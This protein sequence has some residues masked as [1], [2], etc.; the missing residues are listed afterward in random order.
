MD[1]VCQKKI[2]YADSL[3][4]F[5]LVNG[6]VD[7]EIKED[8]LVLWGRWGCVDIGVTTVAVVV[9]LL[10]LWGCWGCWFAG[11]V[12]SLE[13]WGRWGC[14][15]IGVTW[16]AVVVGML[17]IWGCLGCRVPGVAGIVHLS[18]V[19]LQAS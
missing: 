10:G 3:T 18:Y 16:V 7:T 5:K 14:G 4:K 11:D 13:L 8:M 6:L 2:F 15:D 17:V 9:G 12:G 19:N 1:C